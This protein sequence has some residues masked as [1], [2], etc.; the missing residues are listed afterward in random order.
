MNS[1]CDFEKI[2]FREIEQAAFRIACKTQIEAMRVFI[3]DFDDE[4]CKIRDRKG[5]ESLGQREWTVT[6]Y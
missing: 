5:Y 6:L 4:I 3:K 2:S 1:I